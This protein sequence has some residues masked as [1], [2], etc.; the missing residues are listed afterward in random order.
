MKKFFSNFKKI[1]AFLLIIPMMFVFASCKKKN[2]NPN[3]PPTSSEQPAGG[4]DSS[5][6]GDS[7]SG[8][9]G[10][11]GDGGSGGSG[12]ESPEPEPEIDTFNLVVDYKLPDYL[13]GVLK[14]SSLTPAVEDG[15]TLPVFTGTEYEDYFDG[16]YTSADYAENSKIEN[17]KV[18]AEKDDN[19]TIYAKWTTDDLEKYFCTAGVEFSYNKKQAIP[20]SYSGTNPIVIISKYVKHNG[21]EYYV[22]SISANCFKD[23]K[24]IKEFRTSMIDFEVGANAFDASSLET[25]DFS[26]IK[27]IGNYGFK[28]TNVKKVAFSSV[29]DEISSAIFYDCKNL[30]EI[31]LSKVNSSKISVV[32]VDFCSGCIKLTTIDLPAQITTIKSSAFEGCSSLESLSFFDNSSITTVENR[33]FAN[34]AKLENVEIK[35]QIVSYGTGVFSGSNVK[36]MTISNMFYDSIY[37]DFKFSTKF[38]DLSSTLESLTFVGTG[39]TKIY[40]NYL[41][42]YS[43]LKTVVMSNSIT[44]IGEGAFDGCSNLENITFSTELYGDRLNISTLKSTK[45]YANI[46]AELQSNSS[47]QKIINNTLVYVS[48]TVSGEFVI[49]DAE[50]VVADIFGANKNITSVTISKNVKDINRYAFYNSKVTSITVSSENTNFAVQ[51]GELEKFDAGTVNKDVKVHYSALYKLNDA[52]EKE[53]LISYVADNSGGLFIVPNTVTM[54]YNS[55]FKSNVRPYFIYYNSSNATL[56][57]VY[58]EG[59]EE[60]GRYLIGNATITTYGNNSCC[61]IYKYFD[62]DTKDYDFTTE[63]DF[64]F[65][66][67]NGKYFVVVEESDVL[68]GGSSVIYSYYLLDTTAKSGSKI[69]NIIDTIYPNF[70]V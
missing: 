28:G 10:N 58:R 25:I 33:A 5:G 34:C 27:S 32:P 17:T 45:W 47:N 61:E 18:F 4:D 37:S 69:K 65:A 21:S 1:F 55:A 50:Y 38:G 57:L 8:N 16:W 9:E 6:G 35:S 54:V 7:S 29:L 64:N 36:N 70:A 30:E 26:K 20:I 53:T 3:N 59:K 39:I 43:A 60:H 68:G 40:S 12:T 11:A 49:G 48:N 31:D 66:G 13:N 51:S 19:L 44:E 67:L 52:G 42:N 46:E 22:D 24:V 63:T 62:K 14:N 23:N 2:D 41:K 15:Y 56:N